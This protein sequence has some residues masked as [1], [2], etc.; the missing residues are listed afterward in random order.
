MFALNI[1]NKIV[2]R[3]RFCNYPAAAKE[4][5]EVGG[6]IDPN[7]EALVASQPDL[8]ILLPEHEK[9]KRHL[10]E[11][12][13]KSLEVDNKTI[14]DIINSIKTIGDSC[15]ARTEANN[16]I[17]NI[18]KTIDQIKLKTK[19]AKRPTTIISI[20]RTIGEGT[21]KD[22]YI[23]GAKTYFSELIDLAGGVNAFQIDRGSYPTLSAEGLIHLNPDII[24]DLVAGLDLSSKNKKDI[25]KEWNSIRSVNAVKNGRVIILDSN[26]IVIPGPRFILLLKDFANIIH[27][28]ID[29]NFE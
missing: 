5:P 15:G 4:I 18:N 22:V 12:N 14:S 11:L 2:G 8:V 16:L 1:G 19:N 21:L 20:G 26:Y 28:E 23:A 9:I 27:P 7:Y 3:T 25:L 13:I 24:I 17:A 6:Y 29:W 10:T